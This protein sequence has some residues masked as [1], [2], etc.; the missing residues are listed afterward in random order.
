MHAEIITIG[1]EILIGQIVDTN[2]QWL[3]KQLNEIGVSVYQITS[4]QDDKG[5]ILKAVAEAESNA[6]IVIL[7]GGLGPTKDDITKITLAEYFQDT[8]V[9]KPEIEEHIKHLFAK[10]KYRFTDMDMKQAMLPSTCKVL[11]NYLGTASGMW[12][13]KEDKVI[14]SL[15]GVPNEMKGLIENDVIPGIRDKFHLPFII[16]K[17]LHTYGMGESRLAERLES[18]ENRLPSHVKLAYLPSYGKVRL[19][20]S[21]KG[22]QLEWLQKEIEKETKALRSLVKDILVGEDLNEAL[23]ISINTL[24]RERNLTLSM[25]ESCTGGNISKMITAIPGASN[26]LNGALIAYNEKVKTELLGVSKSTIDK[27]S[28]VSKEVAEEM[29]IACRDLFDSDFAISTTG[30]AGPTT[31]ETDKSVGVVFIGIATPTGSYSKEFYFGKPRSKVIERASVKALELIRK[32][33]LKNPINSLS[34]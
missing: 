14:V 5:H 19:R 1:D 30:N 10:I 31:D 16:H 18:W 20:L 29:A 17:T 27:F 24:M 9:R 11:K 4:V 28:V 13:E 21:A 12:F 22:D 3:S 15:P 2:S 8:L 32:E 6:D 33:I 34:D 26:F 25:A 23:E 7:T